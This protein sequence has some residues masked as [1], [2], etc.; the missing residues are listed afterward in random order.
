MI[1]RKIVYFLFAFIPLFAAAQSTEHKVG[2]K[3]VDEASNSPLAGVIVTAYADDQT[4]II[5]HTTSNAAGHYSLALAQNHKF[6]LSFALLGYQ[7]IK[8][9]VDGQSTVT[10]DVT[11]KQ[12]PINLRE[13]KIKPP[14][15]TH[16]KDTIRYQ[17]DQFAQNM[18][19]TIGDVL[20]KLPG[21]EVTESGAVL[22]N[23][24][25]I[26]RFYIEGINLL[27]DKYGLAV[28][29]VDFRDVNQVEI[30]E[31]HQP[32][33]VLEEIVGS[34]RAAL[35]LKLKDSSKGKWVGNATAGVGTTPFLW[36][37]SAT[38]MQ[39]SAKLQ[40]LN[41][42]KTN[43]TGNNISEDVKN[44][45]IEDLLSGA[46]NN[47]TMENPLQMQIVPPKLKE[48]RYY[49][50]KSVLANT[51][52]IWNLKRD[53][54][55]K[56][57][58]DYTR[59]VLVNETQAEQ[60]YLMADGSYRFSEFSHF[61]SKPSRLDATFNINK[62]VSDF[63]LDN[64]LRTKVS[65]ESDDIATIGTAPNAQS[66]DFRQYTVQNNF[67]FVK[68]IGDKRVSLNSF[69]RYDQQQ[70]LG[71]VLYNDSLGIKQLMQT[72]SFFHHMHAS[73]TFTFNGWSLES[74]LGWKET[75]KHLESTLDG[76]LNAIGLIESAQVNNFQLNETNF[77][78]KPQVSYKKPN[79]S[80]RFNLPIVYTIPRL[81]DNRMKKSRREQF[82]FVNPSAN[83]MVH[84]N[85][86]FRFSLRGAIDNQ[87]NT[88]VLRYLPETTLRSYRLF[89]QGNDSL[90][91][92]TRYSSAAD[93]TYRNPV[94]AVFGG[95]FFTHTTNVN[96]LLAANTFNGPIVLQQ[97]L[98][99][100]N[101]SSVNR[102]AGQ[103]GKGFDRWNASASLQLNY[104]T[105]LAEVMQNRQIITHEIRSWELVPKFSAAPSSWV[106]IDYL[107]N[108][109]ISRSV[110]NNAA[111][112]NSLKQNMQSLKLTVIGTPKISMLAGW[113]YVYNEVTENSS[114][115][116][117]FLDVGIRYKVSPALAF[118]LKGTN[119]F[120]ERN[121]GY[122]EFSN[123]SINSS[124]YLL[125]PA[126]FL[127]S[128]YYKF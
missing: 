18:D 91:R 122:T 34:D 75:V 95:V 90:E 39:A 80:I 28:N 25:A 104:T 115:H 66:G 49:F 19:R 113:E 99:T 52:S 64:T 40:S 62:N 48:S 118:D 32:V 92:R 108:F 112:L 12:Q 36:D 38:A 8:I 21:M 111:R 93:I 116:Q 110:V 106:N 85:P 1:I 78:Y 76:P 56:A 97:L 15:I 87:I 67:N 109:S 50:N 81:H 13:I 55:A 105:S 33:K 83:M 74:R 16:V 45:S 65:W 9:H 14:R 23:G 69:T 98:I 6:I 119:I 27:D 68:L 101:K 102:I 126:N 125:R 89:T 88:E 22:Y 114:L 73:N 82:F 120:N 59:D 20:R 4:A 86:F 63:F 103:I 2:G 61:V 128:M 123:T 42:V 77:Y 121:F 44:Q 41:V 117:Q 60:A 54:S 100:S 43:N 94:S 53:F 107:G 10:R 35:N 7:S 29:N 37:V 124:Y 71:L 5:G 11:L 17:V 79:F 96:G 24:K 30:L 47:V 58:I 57:A 46:E 3:I 51:R 72:A 84:L 31:N 70:I 127:L 26:N